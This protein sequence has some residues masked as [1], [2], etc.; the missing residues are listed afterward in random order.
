MIVNSL[1][2]LLFIYS[3]NE[4]KRNIYIIVSYL[5]ILYTQGLSNKI[6]S[7]TVLER[8]NQMYDFE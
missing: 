6:S 4:L 5:I 1:L 8:Q 2:C 7:N 3:K